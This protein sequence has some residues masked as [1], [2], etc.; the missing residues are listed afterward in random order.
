[1]ENTCV[2]S[3]GF[4]AFGYSTL[5]PYNFADVIQSLLHHVESPGTR[6]PQT[7]QEFRKQLL[8][9]SLSFLEGSW[10]QWSV[11]LL[12]MEVSIF[13][14][15]LDLIL[16]IS[17]SHEY[18]LPVILLQK[19]LNWS[20]LHT[21]SRICGSHGPGSGAAGQ[22]YHHESAESEFQ[23]KETHPLNA[24]GFRKQCPNPERTLVGV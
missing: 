18:K 23:V 16:D 21:C 14:E 1:M 2:V 17:S 22:N 4:Q 9:W 12:L 11:F 20:G 24:I 8:K 19:S 5:P 3:S 15:E 6:A 10:G 7:K 13:L